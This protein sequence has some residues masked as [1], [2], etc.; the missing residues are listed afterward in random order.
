MYNSLS[1]WSISP[2]RKS[3]GPI[4]SWTKNQREECLS[5]PRGS[6]N[7]SRVRVQVYRQG[8]HHQSSAGQAFLGP[9]RSL[10]EQMWGCQGSCEDRPGLCRA[11][12]GIWSF[13]QCGYLLSFKLVGSDDVSHGYHFVPVHGEEVLGNVL[14]STGDKG[15]GSLTWKEPRGKQSQSPNPEGTAAIATIR[16]YTTEDLQT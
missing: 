10:R 7:H 13:C 1:H 4:G 14:E 15:G 8:Q 12:R 2:G 11:P 6:W 5:F 9:P 3:C 16:K